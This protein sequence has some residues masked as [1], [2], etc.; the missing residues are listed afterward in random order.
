[1]HPRVADRHFI[2]EAKPVIEEIRLRTF[3]QQVSLARLTWECP[4]EEAARCAGCDL[5]VLSC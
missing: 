4:R 5:P 1:M 3:R 2:H